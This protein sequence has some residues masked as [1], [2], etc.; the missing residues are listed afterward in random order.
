MVT[1]SIRDL[2]MIELASRVFVVPVDTGLG[3]LAM[4]RLRRWIGPKV[5]ESVRCSSSGDWR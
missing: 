4:M 1:R 2:L 5:L 3:C